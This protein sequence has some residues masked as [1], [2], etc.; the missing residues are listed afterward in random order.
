MVSVV[1]ASLCPERMYLPKQ[2]G[3]GARAMVCRFLLCRM[4]RFWVSGWNWQHECSTVS[5]L[6][7]RPSD[8]PTL[9]QS[10]GGGVGSVLFARRQL[11]R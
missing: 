11:P 5:A 7:G 3:I 6:E 9:A 8:T 4:G 1:Q 2:A 10:G